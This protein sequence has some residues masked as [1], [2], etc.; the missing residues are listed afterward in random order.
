MAPDSLR[1]ALLA[2]LVSPIRQPYLGGAQALV[3]D[4]A[5][6]LAGRGHSVTLYAADGSDPA[7]LPGVRLIAIPV[8][9]DRLRPGDFSGEREDP[10]AASDSA[11]ESAFLSAYG[12][13]AGRSHEYDLIHAHAYDRPAFTIG[14]AQPLPI[15]HTLH[16][17]DLHADI[18]NT[19]RALA[20][21][22]QPRQ[23]LQAWLI[24]VSRW[25]A[26]TYD[27]TCRI[28]EVIPN[29]VDLDAIPFGARA[30]S[31][32]FLLF[33]GRIAPE[34]GAADA[35]AIARA[36]GMRIIMAGGAYDQHYFETR[37]QP[38]LAAEPE[39]V[40]YIGATAHERVWSLM[41]GA[42]AVLVPSHWE[43][44]FG[45]AACE[46]QAAGAP[47]VGYARGGLRDIVTNG[48]T[49]FL[50]EPGDTSAAAEAVP[51]AARLGRAACRDQVAARFTLAR[52]AAA[53]DRLYQRMLSPS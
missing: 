25:C 14:A 35:I 43:E 47:V 5:V 28:D 24:T 38:A 39:M 45:L 13:I 18:S 33:A 31:P 10:G 32:P 8:L 30:A 48:V 11:M 50:V 16:M 15:A 4:L 7:A 51:L 6:S 2:P 52:M 22:H 44:P 37:I 49:G 26:S 40:Q 19:L 36:A 34:K 29:G 3:R 42:T 23:T 27:Q 41:A 1:I 53:H 20:P 46:A 17:P 21:A 9:A 12:A